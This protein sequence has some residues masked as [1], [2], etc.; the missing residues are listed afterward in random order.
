MYAFNYLKPKSLDA[1]AYRAVRT[2]LFFSTQ[3]QGLKVIQ[4]TSPNKGDGKSLMISNLSRLRARSFSR[5][6]L[7]APLSHFS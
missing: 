3:G 4:V 7:R 5:Y 2:A 6:E 1:E